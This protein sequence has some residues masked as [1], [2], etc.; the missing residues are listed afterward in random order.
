MRL[1]FTKGTPKSRLHIQRAPGDDL[2]TEFGQKG[3]FPH[4]LMHYA[5]ERAFGFSRG[6]WGLIESDMTP[7]AVATFAA[8]HGHASAA[9]AK[10][11]DPSIVE[12]LQ[13]ERLVECFEAELWGGPAAIEDL[14]SVADAGFSA[15]LVP[16]VRLD[17]AVVAALRDDIAV[18][19]ARWQALN[20]GQTLS[21]D[22]PPA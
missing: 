11:P 4:D 13:A 14:Q 3:P 9:K 8:A 6:F 21:V 2:Y 10:T 7:D 18:L 20:P 19:N 16:S 5:V 17:G 1:T 22:W 12:L 15:S